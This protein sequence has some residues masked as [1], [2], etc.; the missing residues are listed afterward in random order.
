MTQRLTIKKLQ[1]MERALCLVLAGEDEDEDIE[2]EDY[3]A[4]LDWVQEQIYRRES[5]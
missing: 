1:A 2:R 4:A 3:S 5:K